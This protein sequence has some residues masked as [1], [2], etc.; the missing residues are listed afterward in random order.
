MVAH[1]HR[2]LRRHRHLR[3]LTRH[4][5]LLARGPRG[6]SASHRPHRPHRQGRRSHL[7]D[8]RAA[9]SSPSR[10]SRS[11]AR[12]QVRGAQ[13]AD[14]REDAKQL[15]IDRHIAQ[16]AEGSQGSVFE[17]FLPL[18]QALRE[19]PGSDALMAFALKCRSSTT[20]RWRSRRSEAARQCPPP[21]RHRAAS[22]RA[23]PTRASALRRRRK[24]FR[25]RRTR[26]GP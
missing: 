17:A 26:T 13:A 12:H 10:R 16:L 6:L 4:Q 21:C 14:A 8:L 7:A 5:L 22:A 9:S 1:R 3:P 20:T 15:W 18:A 11:A 2:R 24:V 19:R 25:R 23:A